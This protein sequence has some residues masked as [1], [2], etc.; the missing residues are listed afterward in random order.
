MGSQKSQVLLVFRIDIESKL[1]SLIGTQGQC[2]EFSEFVNTQTI[3]FTIEGYGPVY[4]S[5][6]GDAGEM[7]APAARL[8]LPVV[9]QDRRWGDNPG[10]PA[11][12]DR[13]L[14]LPDIQ[15]DGHVVIMSS[16]RIMKVQRAPH[17][18][19][20]R[21]DIEENSPRNSTQNLRVSKKTHEVKKNGRSAGV[22]KHC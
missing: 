14:F 7:F 10:Q 6:A 13:A 1:E 8:V 22:A 15:R 21:V 11:R 19:K 4:P 5:P 3:G 17:L 12:R 16:K 9:Q 18:W 20:A 2:D